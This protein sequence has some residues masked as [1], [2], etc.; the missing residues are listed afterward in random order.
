[1][2]GLALAIGCFSFINLAT[3]H[4][5]LE[6]EIQEITEELIKDPN[7]V[8]LLVRRGQ[9]YRSNGKYIES[10]LDLERA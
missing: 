7:S 10:L 8:D 6:P 9:V 3:A 1:M 2:T 5:G 4:S